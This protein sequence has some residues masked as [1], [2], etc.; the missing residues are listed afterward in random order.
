M[1]VPPEKVFSSLW[2]LRYTKSLLHKNTEKSG[3]FTLLLKRD[4]IFSRISLPYLPHLSQHFCFNLSYTAPPS[5]YL[6]VKQTSRMVWCSRRRRLVWDTGGTQSRQTRER[7]ATCPRSWGRD[8]S[9]PRRW[10]GRVRSGL[11]VGSCWWILLPLS[12]LP[13]SLE[14]S[15]G[16]RE[17]DCWCGIK[18]RCQHQWAI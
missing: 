17:G 6:H 3:D 7:P 9:H 14:L 13:T 11:G 16:L 18:T 2:M 5:L 1:Y 10:P 8:T 4:S 15:E 12:L